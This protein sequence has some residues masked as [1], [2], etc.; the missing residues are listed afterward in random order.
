[1]VNAT[2]NPMDAIQATGTL[3]DKFTLT[4]GS[5]ANTVSCTFKA[6]K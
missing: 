3:A 1:M 6:I 2:T 4:H 5:G